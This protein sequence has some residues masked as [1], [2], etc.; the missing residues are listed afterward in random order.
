[1]DA[2][3]VTSCECTRIEDVKHH[4]NNKQK[5]GKNVSKENSNNINGSFMYGTLFCGLWHKGEIGTGT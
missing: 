4:M 1:M 2:R 3:E 5:R